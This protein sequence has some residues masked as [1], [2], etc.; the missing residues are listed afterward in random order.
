MLAALRHRSFA[1]FMAA[2]FLA[3]IAVQMEGVAV[4]WQV[5]ALTRNPLDLGLIGLAQF[6]PFIVLV[7]PAGHVADRVNRR[8]ILAMC[9]V[10]ELLC[11]AMLLV[12][13]LIGFKTAWPVFA[14]LM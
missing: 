5:Y 12:F 6:L 13:T 8:L 7:L 4:G 9:Y 3:T 1:L 14:V 10:V 11:A 2:R